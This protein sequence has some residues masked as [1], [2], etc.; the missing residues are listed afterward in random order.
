MKC[1]R[2]ISDL[3]IGLKT[4][5]HAFQNLGGKLNGHPDNRL[6]HNINATFSGIEGKSIINNIHKEIA[7]STGSACTTQSVNP[8]HVLLALGMNDSDAHSS[9]RIG[10]GRFNT[11]DEIKYATNSIISS[12]HRIKKIMK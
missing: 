9:I 7:I 6:L 1:M 11:H 5:M 8:S 2:K 4:L 10:V 3:E 12:I